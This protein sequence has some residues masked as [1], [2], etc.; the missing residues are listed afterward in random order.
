MDEYD[1]ICKYCNNS[2]PDLDCDNVYRCFEKDRCVNG[3]GTCKRFVPIHSQQLSL[4]ERLI[5]S[6]S[7]VFESW[8]SRRTRRNSL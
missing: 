8:T 5:N 6:I 1:K 3:D 2:F 7:E 4:F